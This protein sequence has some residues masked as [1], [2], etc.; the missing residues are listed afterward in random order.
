MSVLKDNEWIIER[1]NPVID[2]FIKN[3]EYR[4]I[5]LKWYGRPTPFWTVKK[6]FLLMSLIMTL[7]LI[8]FLAWKYY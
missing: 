1:L 2:D 4:N 7:M 8:I 5:Y 6:V 3:E